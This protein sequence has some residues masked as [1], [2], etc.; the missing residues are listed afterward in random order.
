MEESNI[1]TLCIRGATDN[2]MDDVERAVDDGVNTYKNL[3]RV[4]IEHSSTIQLRM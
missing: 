2:I 3:T 4:C 1:A